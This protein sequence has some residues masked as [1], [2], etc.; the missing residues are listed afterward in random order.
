[1]S[2]SDLVVDVYLSALKAKGYAP[3]VCGSDS[4]PDILVADESLGLLGI[5]V[6]ITSELEKYSL[7]ERK[8]M[9]IIKTKNLRIELNDL[10]K[11]VPIRYVQWTIPEIPEILKKNLQTKTIALKA[12][13]TLEHR[14]VSPEIVALARD[15]FDPATVFVAKARPRATEDSGSFN[16]REMTRFHLDEKQVEIA[17]GLDNELTLLK[18]C[19][20]SGKTLVLVARAKW[21]HAQHPNW[22]IR[23]VC[24]NN[25]LKQL[26]SDYLGNLRRVTVE[27]FYEY[28]VRTGNRFKIKNANEFDAARELAQHK[29][30][31]IAKCADAILIDEAQDFLPSWVEYLVGTLIEGRG[32]L[33]AV[34]DDDQALYRDKPLEDLLANRDFH[35]RTLTK[36]YR[37]T[38]QILRVVSKLLPESGL[39]GIEG[40][41]DGPNPELIYVTEGTKSDQ[42]A[43][44]IYQDI[45]YLRATREQ[46]SWVDFG[47]L[48]A[49]HYQ[50]EPV[51]GRIRAKL[52]SEFGNSRMIQILH[53][54]RFS[55]NFQDLDLQHD[56]MKALTMHS[57]K[58][59]EFR[60]VFLVGLDKL[61]D[62]FEEVKSSWS[63]DETIRQARLNLVGPTR[64]KEQLNM[65][66]SKDNVFLKR[67]I[68]HENLVQ[69]R[70]YPDD[71]EGKADG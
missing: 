36:P 37:S 6:F 70:R 38:K 31:G 33:L 10:S 42:M 50:L 43:E 3:L 55:S 60:F 71:Y 8:R 63:H 65:Y 40:A 14:G 27:T 5:D 41:L 26:L 13:D 39:A 4:L 16:S 67:L 25:A 54:N 69:L 32:G 20:G 47:I 61:A 53:K 44:A 19:A 21:L 64:A 35:V 58:G 57:A 11:D 2:D 62:G 9:H 34:G 56:S 24:Y 18:G 68:G 51:A 17:K 7:E 15:R 49:N 30:F 23:V 22:N 66:Y 59:L 29:R 45:A 46:V 12:I 48:F 1:M 28:Q 52:A